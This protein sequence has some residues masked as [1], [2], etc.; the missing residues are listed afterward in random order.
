MAEAD[1]IPE[2]IPYRGIVLAGGSVTH[3][4]WIAFDCP[5]RQE[6]VMVNAA[7]GRWPRW[8]FTSR[9]RVGVTLYPSV[10]TTHANKKCH[11]FIRRGLVAWAFDSE[12]GTH[13]E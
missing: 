2:E 10:D 1:L 13:D 9:F 12:M 4:K 3:P 5:C 8:R 6:R 11:Y 7:E